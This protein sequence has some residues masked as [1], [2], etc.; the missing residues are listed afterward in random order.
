MHS[1]V[2]I[3]ASTQPVLL[4]VEGGAR[5]GGV[6]LA[7]PNCVQAE[8]VPCDG[9]GGESSFDVELLD[10]FLW[11]SGKEA[12]SPTYASGSPANLPGTD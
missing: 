5:G 3:L 8:A 11:C 2:W 1:K 9:Q 7:L 10:G 12:F 4:G 6:G